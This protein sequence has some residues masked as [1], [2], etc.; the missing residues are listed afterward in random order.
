LKYHGYTTYENTFMLGI[1][2]AKNL[3]NATFHIAVRW[4][5]FGSN[6]IAI[7]QASKLSMPAQLT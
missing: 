1:N 4:I 7:A 5:F 3:P 2:L 6:I